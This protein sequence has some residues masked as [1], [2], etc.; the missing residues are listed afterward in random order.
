[1]YFILVTL[2]LSVFKKKIASELNYHIT[3]QN[4]NK[5]KTTKFDNFLNMKC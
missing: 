2:S 1:M 3:N 4:C 5:K